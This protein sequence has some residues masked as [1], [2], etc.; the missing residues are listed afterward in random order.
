MADVH[1]KAKDYALRKRLHPT[2]SRAAKLRKA[3]G[4]KQFPPIAD[5]MIESIKINRL[6]REDAKSKGMY[7]E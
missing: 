1:F 2:A 3:V 4:D 6:R 5:A 7:F